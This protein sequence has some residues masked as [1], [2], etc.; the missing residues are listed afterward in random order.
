[1]ALDLSF[2]EL[3][4]TATQNGGVNGR[5][6]LI[7]LAQIDEDPDQPRRAFS[8][9]ELNQLAESIRSVGIL[10][11]IS[12]RLIH[13]SGRYVINMGT[14]RYRA[15]RLAGLDVV[16]AIIQDKTEPDRYAQ[17]IEN[18]QRDDLAASEIATFVVAQLDAGEKQ[19]D[20]ARRLGKPKDW[21]SRYAA[22]PR[23]PDFLRA[24]LQ[25]SSIR[26]VYELYQAWR[27]M[28]VPVERACS[29]Q[30]S[31]TDAAAKRAA[32]EARAS[33]PAAMRPLAANALQ[34]APDAVGKEEL[35]INSAS[36]DNGQGLASKP[37]S[38]RGSKHRGKVNVAILVRHSDRSGCL[39]L[40]R[41]ASNG[42]RFAFVRFGDS[43]QI[44]ELPAS[45][46]QIEEIIQG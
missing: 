34:P 33:S 37:R 25:T 38:I 11:P 35:T 42:A 31:F 39:L 21:V 40:E 22:V 14:R 27:E 23:M 20:I 28:P 30:A 3:V 16:P 19:A 29:T 32:H 26:A 18:I 24:K 1:M 5:P 36:A 8:E 12:V 46:L 13:G 7:P 4:D 2:K 41:P 15:A 17:M 9:L 44:E 6:L 45:E 10:Q 43:G